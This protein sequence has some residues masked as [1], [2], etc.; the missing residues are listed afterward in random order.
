MRQGPPRRIEVPQPP[1]VDERQLVADSLFGGYSDNGQM[2]PDN[3]RAE[4]DAQLGNPDA[5]PRLDP[6]GYHQPVRMLTVAQA[7]Q[8]MGVSTSTARRLTDGRGLPALRLFKT[9]RI[10]SDHAWAMGN[11]LAAGRNVGGGREWSARHRYPRGM[12]DMGVPIDEVAQTLQ[13]HPHTLWRWWRSLDAAAR[14]GQPPQTLLWRCAGRRDNAVIPEGV[15]TSW[16]IPYAKSALRLIRFAEVRRLTPHQ[17]RMVASHQRTSAEQLPDHQVRRSDKVSDA[18]SGLRVYTMAEAAAVLRLSVSGAR[19]AIA[20]AGIDVWMLAGA[21]RVGCD[22]L[23]QLLDARTEAV[24]RK[25]QPWFTSDRGHDPLMVPITDAARRIGVTVR[26]LRRRAAAGKFT[27]VTSRGQLFARRH[28]V[29][30]AIDAAQAAQ[31]RRGNDEQR[32]AEQCGAQLT[33]AHMDSFTAWVALRYPDIDTSTVLFNRAGAAQMAGCRPS[34]IE[35]LV[36]EGL[37]PAQRCGRDLRIRTVDLMGAGVFSAKVARM[38]PKLRVS[39]PAQCRAFV[40][41]F[42][43]FDQAAR[44]VGRPASEVRYLASIGTLNSVR[45]GRGAHRLHESEVAG[46]GMLRFKDTAR[47][48][49]EL[50]HRRPIG[51]GCTVNDAAHYLRVC[52]RTVLRWIDKGVLT[53]VEATR[54]KWRR[55]ENG[56]YRKLPVPVN[57]G[58]FLVSERSVRTVRRLRQVRGLQPR[59]VVAVTPNQLGEGQAPELQ[60]WQQFQL[61]NE[62]GAP[63]DEYGD[64]IST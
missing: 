26:T 32:T 45:F 56:S 10:R 48:Y 24:N 57:H 46:P 3:M 34:V 16:G 59:D 4:F 29:Q 35:N 36:R 21:A 37:I 1:E 63:L 52:E 47:P 14:P 44:I 6:S 58:G 7:A 23:L 12:R 8:L 11:R 19:K 20:R 43:T 64:P 25:V 15:L 61:V 5:D 41:E 39:D 55:T 18:A 27:L 38:C 17:K 54:I 62:D 13:V 33:D 9:L 49:R 28:E 50:K 30:A 2:P 60:P 51:W 31:P 42:L 53:A 22:D 40:S